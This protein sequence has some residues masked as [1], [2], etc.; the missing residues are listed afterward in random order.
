VFKPE[1]RQKFVKEVQPSNACWLSDVPTDLNILQV[2][3]TSKLYSCVL[4]VSEKNSIVCP[5]QHKLIGFNNREGKFLL[6]G[7]TYASKFGLVV[8]G[9]QSR[10]PVLTS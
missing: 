3:A 8:I 6:R 2:Y 9:R 5:I 1:E 7:T 10:V 4:R